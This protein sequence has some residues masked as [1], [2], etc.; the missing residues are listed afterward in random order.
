MSLRASCVGELAVRFLARR[1]P[2]TVTRVFRS[3][4]YFRTGDDFVLVLKGGLRSPV[5]INIAGDEQALSIFRAGDEW[6]F[7]PGGLALG[8]S[9]VGVE[10]AAVHRSRLTKGMR[11]ELP[12]TSELKKGVAML[13]SLYD[14]SI[15][16]PSLA[17]DEALRGFV[18]ETLLP[19]AKGESKNLRERD[20]YLPLIGRGG[21]F[22][23]AGD[24]FV[25][26]FL[27]TFNFVARSS[28]SSQVKVPRAS[29]YKRTVP[30]SAAVVFYAALGFV[31]EGLERLIIESLGGTGGFH[32]E[33]LDVARRGHTSGI[34]MSLGVLL[35]EAALAQAGGEEGALGRCLDIL[36]AA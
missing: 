9:E 10:G 6:A 36:W 14:V 3:S 29:L 28:K 24:D 15:S 2:G 13:R 17:R 27:S 19:F 26:G 23:P 4:V 20:R 22:T 1:M 8:P 32:G 11:V 16:G 30:E 21:G 33:L 18:A 7:S 12:S 35:C 31:D 5:T 34:D 25:A